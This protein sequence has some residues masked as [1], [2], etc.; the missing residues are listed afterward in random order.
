LVLAETGY[1]MSK[2]GKEFNR[3]IGELARQGKW[4]IAASVIAAV[5]YPRGVKKLLFKSLMWLFGKRVF[6]APTDLF[7]G[8]VEIEAEDNHDFKERLAEI[9][10]STLVI[11][12]EEDP[13]YPIREM[14]AGIPK[15]KLIIYKGLGHDAV[16]KRQFIED[17]LAFLT[18]DTA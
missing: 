14:A 17:V 9:K 5:M 3:H 4:R 16:L 2:E 1:A 11:G 6:G 12:G 15:A 7:A 10:V 8:L 13:Y 18:E